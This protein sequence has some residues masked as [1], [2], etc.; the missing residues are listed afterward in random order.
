MMRVAVALAV[1]GSAILVAGGCGGRRELHPA[2]RVDGEELELAIQR[3]RGMVN[4][5]VDAGEARRQ[6]LEP[7]NVRVSADV[8][9]RSVGCCWPV[10]EIAYQ[11][12]ERG[13]ASEGGIRQAVRQALKSVERELKFLVEVQIPESRDPA[14]I[15]FAL[16]TNMGVEY[17]PVAVEAPAFLREVVSPFDPSTPPGAMYYYVVRFPIRGGPGIPGVGPEVSSLSLVVKDGESE[18]AVTFSL[19][20]WQ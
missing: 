16:R 7:A 6:A 15:G 1:L 20:R 12:A 9:I 14:S 19:Y 18:G 8:I 11:I 2:L 5:G 4:A 3:G 17:P 10:K 13:D